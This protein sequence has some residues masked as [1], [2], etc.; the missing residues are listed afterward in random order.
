[1]TINEFVE[2]TKENFTL[3]NFKSIVNS[4]YEKKYIAVI[5]KMLETIPKKNLPIQIKTNKM[6]NEE[7]YIKI[8]DNF[9][10]Y[11][12]NELLINFKR[13]VLACQG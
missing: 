1:M 8:A 13:I 10:R 6:N 7:G 4:K 5:K 11:F 3:E 9:E 12:R 2:Y